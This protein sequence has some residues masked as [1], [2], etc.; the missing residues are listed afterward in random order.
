[1]RGDLKFLPLFVGFLFLALGQRAYGCGLDKA[2]AYFF[3][4]LIVK[5]EKQDKCTRIEIHY[6][7]EIPS[8]EN[9]VWAYPWV[10]FDVENMHFNLDI[11]NS[12]KDNQDLQN[13]YF[14]LPDEIIK[15][16]VIT[17][18]YEEYST[19]KPVQDENGTA[20]TQVSFCNHSVVIDNLDERIAQA[21]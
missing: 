12:E 17:V 18:E 16:A 14:C 8:R 10:T 21:K 3:D 7:K 4:K 20:M 13:V 19:K 15:A 11:A 1:M 2:D 9:W 6:P 5:S